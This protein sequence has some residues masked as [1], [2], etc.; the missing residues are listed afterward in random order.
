MV[1]AD[2]PG[3]ETVNVWATYDYGDFTFAVESVDTED[4]TGAD[5]LDLTTAM[6]YYSMGNG[7]ITLR[8]TDGDYNGVD[9]DKFT[10]SPSYAF[11]D[12]VFGLVEFSSEELGDADDEDSLAVELIYSF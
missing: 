1:Y 6:V 4:A 2:D 11:S 5:V 3:Y 10:V 9:F 8:M 12:N 7:G